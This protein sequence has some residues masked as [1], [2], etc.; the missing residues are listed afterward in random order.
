[1]NQHHWASSCGMGRNS[2]CGVCLRKFVWKITNQPAKDDI[3]FVD[4][5]RLTMNLRRKVAVL[6]CFD[7][8]IKELNW[9]NGGFDGKTSCVLYF[10]DLFFLVGKSNAWIFS[11]IS[12]G[13]SSNCN[14]D[15]PRNIDMTVSKWDTPLHMATL[16][17]FRVI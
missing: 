5:Q 8:N 3:S 14:V 11:A 7:G 6:R 4:Y 15:I 17:W 9:I 12:N 16:R 2:S 10:F 13:I 1:M